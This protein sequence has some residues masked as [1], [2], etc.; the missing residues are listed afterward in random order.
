MTALNSHAGDDIRI[1]RA[2]LGDLDAVAPLFDAYRVFYRQPSDP[3]RAH[4]FMRE[5]L[6]R[7]DS[8]VF[9]ALAGPAPSSTAAGFTQLYPS[10]TSVGA[11]RT[12]ILNDLFVDPAFRKRSVADRLMDEAER[13][14]AAD[15]ARS[16][17]LLTAHDNAAARRL[18]ERRRWSLDEQ[19]VR[20]V[21]RFG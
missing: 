4:A 10:F 1:R 14:A 17:S 5:R 9:I 2:G 21:K 6:E 3:A 12:W 7:G 15:G 11:A 8:A 18:Y 20:Y 13:F 16:I 19:F